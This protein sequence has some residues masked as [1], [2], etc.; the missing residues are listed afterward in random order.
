MVLNNYTSI[1][2]DTIHFQSE[3]KQYSFVAFYFAKK[4][5]NYADY[6]VSIS[7]QF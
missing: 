2:N 6:R 7:N 5:N 4:V 1:Y 3:K